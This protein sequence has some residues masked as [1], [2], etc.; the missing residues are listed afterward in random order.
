L[1]RSDDE[2]TRFYLDPASG[3]ILAKVA[4]A[5]RGYRW[6]HQALH[7]F[8][9]VESTTGWYPMM[10]MLMAGVTFVC[11]TGAVLSITRWRKTLRS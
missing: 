8:D 6:L 7:R 3:R 5:E 9:F 1:I 4:S 11:A 10:L 2:R